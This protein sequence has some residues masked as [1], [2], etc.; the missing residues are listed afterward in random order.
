MDALQQS[1]NEAVAN[2]PTLFLEK[3]ITKKLQ[4][5]GITATKALSSKIAKRILSGNSEPFKYRGG[6]PE[7]DV[8]LT[9]KDADVDEIT[10]AVALFC[11]AKL[12]KILDDVAERVSKSVL[13]DLKSR[14]VQEHAL[15]ETDLSEF[16]KRLEDRWGKPLGQLR[17]LLTMAR[18]WGQD[19]IPRRN[20]SKTSKK[21]H[22]RDIL[23]RLHVR[24]CQATDEIICLLENGFADGAMARWRTLHEIGVVA[25]VISKHGEVIAQRYLAHQAVESRRAMNKYLRCCGPL[26]YRPLSAR[27]VKRITKA[28]EAAI[29]KYGKEFDADYGWATLHLKKKRVTFSDLEVEAGHPE[30]RSHY[31]IGNDNVHAGVKSI[32][33]RLGLL[34]DYSRLLAGRSNAGMMEPGQNTAHTLT[35]ISALACLPGKFDD[36]VI[37]QM[38]RMLRDEIPGSFY[39]A[40]KR[41][42][43]DD[44]QYKTLMRAHI[45][46]D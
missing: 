7:G 21:I 30:M 46:N 29:R 41:L 26:G 20:S 11:D 34:D 19:A 45:S 37:A 5:Q 3:L 40:D 18:E 31:Q 1:L 14:W 2:L 44:K 12:P 24:A 27:E 42:R 4:D 39:H 32:F 22:L 28:Y 17:M 6:K 36:L 13:K 35:Q 23:I 10:K 9:F 43:R 16:R 8:T 15:Q 38:I 33:V 25:A